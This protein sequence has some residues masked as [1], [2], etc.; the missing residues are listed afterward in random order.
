MMFEPLL[1]SR[2]GTNGADGPRS[3]MGTIVVRM[4]LSVSVIRI[5]FSAMTFSRSR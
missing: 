1:A 3:V 2:T 5:T 4:R